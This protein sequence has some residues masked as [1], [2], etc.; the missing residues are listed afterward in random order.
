MTGAARRPSTPPRR[1]H[2]LGGH[3]RRARSAIAALA[4]SAALLL[5]G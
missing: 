4:A 5:G 1:A 2:D 3:A